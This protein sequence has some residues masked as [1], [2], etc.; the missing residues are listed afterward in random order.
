LLAEE[1]E[2]DGGAGRPAIQHRCVVADLL[3]FRP[4][5]ILEGLSHRNDAHPPE[6]R[7]PPRVL[8]ELRRGLTTDEELLER[9]LHHVVNGRLPVA[10]NALHRGTN[11]L[12]D[13]ALQFR[14]RAWIILETSE[15]K[16]EVA[17]VELFEGGAR[18]DS[19]GDRL[20]EVRKRD[21]CS[22]EQ[23]G[24]FAVSL[25]DELVVETRHRGSVQSFS[26]R[27]PP[28]HASTSTTSSRSRPGT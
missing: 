25:C 28:P 15:R 10:A 24:S 27:N 1:R 5:A 9:P 21:H 26:W 14:D 17:R 22:R 7:A 12:D 18:G 2:L 20:G 13:V 16:I 4:A 11:G 19:G 3:P 8:F 6:E 23:N